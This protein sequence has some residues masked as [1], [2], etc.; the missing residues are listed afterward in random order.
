MGAAPEDGQV[1]GGRSTTRSTD[2]L[3]EKEDP[4][5]KTDR[6]ETREFRGVDGCRWTVSILRTVYEWDPDVGA[7]AC[8]DMTLHELVTNEFITETTPVG[9]A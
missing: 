7:W 8:S 5:T 6:T 9:G 1:D 3:R 2:P 4:M